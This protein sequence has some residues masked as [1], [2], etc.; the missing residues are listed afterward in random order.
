MAEFKVGD[1]VRLVDQ[2]EDGRYV[3]GR[4]V[5]PSISL[6]KGWYEVAITHS[7]P[8]PHLADLV[9]PGP[10]PQLAHALDLEHID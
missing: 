4:I 1:R 8:S 3:A 6:S 5:E 2:L 7:D 10:L 9:G